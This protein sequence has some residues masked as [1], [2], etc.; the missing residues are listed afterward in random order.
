MSLKLKYLSISVLFDLL[1]LGSLTFLYCIQLNIQN[2]MSLIEFFQYDLVN[3][4]G[5]FFLF[6]LLL[7]LN[8]PILTFH[9]KTKKKGRRFLVFQ[10]FKFLEFIFLTLSSIYLSSDS[11]PYRKWTLFYLFTYSEFFYIVGSFFIVTLTMLAS[12]ARLKQ[13]YLKGEFSNL[14]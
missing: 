3:I 14:E 1:Y 10:Y 11:I 12:F 4:E 6:L 7:I 8:I 2:P 13:G 5:I 9:F